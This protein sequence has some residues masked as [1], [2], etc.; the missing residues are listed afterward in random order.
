MLDMLSSPLQAQLGPNETLL[1][2]GR[3]K[4]GILVRSSDVFLIPFSL[5]WAGFAFFWEY[6]SL[7]RLKQR[8]PRRESNAK[9]ME[10]TA[11]FSNRIT[12]IIFEQADRVF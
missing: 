2:S 4:Q 3:P 10:G 12:N 5:F 6:K 9:V 11:N 8:L 1:W 7:S